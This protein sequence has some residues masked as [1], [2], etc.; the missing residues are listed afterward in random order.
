MCF[1]GAS[2]DLSSRLNEQKGFHFNCNK[3]NILSSYRGKT[4]IIGWFCIKMQPITLLKQATKTL[5]SRYSHSKTLLLSATEVLFI[6]DLLYWVCIALHWCLW[7]CLQ[8]LMPPWRN[9]HFCTDEKYLMVSISALT[10][11]LVLSADVGVYDCAVWHNRLLMWKQI[12]LRDAI[13]FI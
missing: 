4:V 3:T 12:Y 13:K 7:Y 10:S 5:H 2:E 9:W 8:P 11:C 6:A 1:N